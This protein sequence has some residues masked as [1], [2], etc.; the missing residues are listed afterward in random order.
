MPPARSNLNAPPPSSG[1][2]AE[3]QIPWETFVQI[4]LSITI[5][6]YQKMR[7]DNTPRINWAEDTF[8]ACLGENYMDPIAYTH[9][10]RVVVRSKVHTKEIKSGDVTPR[11]AKEID[12]WLFGTWERNYRN[13]YF[14]WEG[15]L[16]SDKSVDPD[17]DHLTSEY[18]TEGINRFVDEEY[19]N[20]VEDAGM[21]GYIIA[22]EVSSIVKE[23]NRSMH[24]RRRK[25]PLSK[26]DHLLQAPPLENFT[27]IYTST[28]NRASCAKKVRLHHL[29][30]T[31]DFK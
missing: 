6:A 15:K 27:D 20:E 8:S 31:F 18:I 21:L 5:Q 2:P 14:A 22:G 23:I 17:H 1:S 16:I 30:L 11:K 7:N 19:S 9:N 4:V 13:I 24:D 10:M 29:F 25:Q 3:F 26:S 28:H 12:I